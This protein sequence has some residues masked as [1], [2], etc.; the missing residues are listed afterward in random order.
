MKKIQHEKSTTQ[1]ECNTK[2]MKHEKNTTQIKK[3]KVK[4]MAENEKSV[5][6][7]KCNM[8]KVQC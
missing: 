6:K 2:N 1:K 4:D 3:W 8:K 5:I 7:K